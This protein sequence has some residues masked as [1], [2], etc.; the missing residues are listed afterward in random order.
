MDSMSVSANSALIYPGMKPCEWCFE[1][2]DSKWQE[3]KRVLQQLMEHSLLGMGSHLD[4]L[5]L[6]LEIYHNEQIICYKTVIVV[7]E[8]LV[9]PLRHKYRYITAL[10]TMCKDEAK[11][12][13][14]VIY[15]RV[16]L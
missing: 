6:V 3:R 14:S 9:P 16:V 5:S 12:Y 11:P 2:R 13:F 4:Q 1:R 15:T 10:R 7:L 8:R